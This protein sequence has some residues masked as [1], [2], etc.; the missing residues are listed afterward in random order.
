MKDIAQNNV[1]VA[2]SVQPWEKYLAE[3][4]T[5]EQYA[6]ADDYAAHWEANRAHSIGGS[7]AGILLGLSLWATPVELWL[8][9]TGKL[10]KSEANA[11]SWPL[12]FG[13]HAETI[14]RDWY[15]K[16][17]PT[18]EVYSGTLFTF[19]ALDGYRH[20]NLD[21]IIMNDED[22]RTPGVLEIKTSRSWSMWHDDNGETIIPPAYL[23]QV[24]HYMSV[25]GFNWARFVVMVGGYEPF[26]ITVERDEE[27]E[28]SLLENEAKFWT[29]VKMPKMMQPMP[30]NVDDIAK[31][32][33]QPLS[34]LETI[35]E[36][37]AQ[38][39]ES[40]ARRLKDARETMKQAK[41][42]A[43]RIN[44]ALA[45]MIGD[46]AGL[47]HDGLRAT[48]GMRAGKRSKTVKI[49]EE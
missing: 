25:T 42:E 17:H 40:L 43:S 1:I 7:D 33:P 16:E 4:V 45:V 9:K 10:K 20:A 15:A 11:D 47:E 27:R 48:L 29:C 2:P 18:E 37:Q 26:T 30:V 44:D 46:S 24:D 19:K 21:G 39:F 12:W 49:S 8:E 34:T 14:L 6:D 31:L 13:H 38:E 5:F 36:S 22:H 41:E 35:P 32:Y 3:G 28:A 23:A